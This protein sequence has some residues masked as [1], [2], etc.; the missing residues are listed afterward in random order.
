MTDSPSLQDRDIVPS[1]RAV[2]AAA[3]ILCTEAPDPC[4]ACQEVAR[5]MLDAGITVDFRGFR[6][7]EVLAR[8]LAA[9]AILGLKRGESLFWSFAFA[10]SFL[11]PFLWDRALE[12]TDEEC[13]QLGR[14]VEEMLVKVPELRTH[15][16]RQ[17]RHLRTPRVA[18]RRGM[19]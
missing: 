16:E 6:P 14:D 19:S 15:I 1:E 11:S 5:R 3:R 10:G 17:V 9:Y 4:V 12:L 2:V 13:Y 18:P 7:H 8:G